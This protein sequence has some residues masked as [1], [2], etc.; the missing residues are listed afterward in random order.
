[1]ILG[2]WVICSRTFSH[3]WR[4]SSKIN[5]R[6]GSVL[7]GLVKGH[8]WIGYSQR[9]NFEKIYWSNLP[10]R[11]ISCNPG[12]SIFYT[13]S[14]LSVLR[15]IVIV[16]RHP[17][18]CSYLFMQYHYKHNCNKRKLGCRLRL[19]ATSSLFFY[20]LCTWFQPNKSV[21]FSSIHKKW[22]TKITIFFQ[23]GTCK[24]QS[25]LAMIPKH[26]CLILFK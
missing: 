12:D 3:F 9:N 13:W 21:L 15:L 6:P 4:T 20:T 25:C 1:M 14:L 26:K 22:V 2:R 5:D 8:I 19:I 11:S 23:M 7:H 16:F 17:I 24:F 18:V 10:T